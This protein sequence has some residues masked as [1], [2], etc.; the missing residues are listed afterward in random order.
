LGSVTA[1]QQQ[2]ALDSAAGTIDSKLRGRY[3][4]PLQ[5]PIPVEIT[6][7]CCRIAAWRLMSI[8]GFNPMNPGDAVIRDSYIDTMRWLDQ[9]QRQAAHPNVV[10]ATT[11]Q[12]PQPVVL[13]SSVAYLNSGAGLPNRGW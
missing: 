10:Q 6:E 12:T 7:A 8:R 2:D 13:S 1:G 4:L 3:A 9:V 5:P 11:G